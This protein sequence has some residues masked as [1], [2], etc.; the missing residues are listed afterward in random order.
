MEGKQCLMLASYGSQHFCLN[1][2][3][4][5]SNMAL[6]DSSGLDWSRVPRVKPVSSRVS[7]HVDV[8]IMTAAS[9]YISR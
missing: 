8:L 2:A 5:D 7:R 4:L 3:R 9:V 6:Y 1:E